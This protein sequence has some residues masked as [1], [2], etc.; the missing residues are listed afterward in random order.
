AGASLCVNAGA[1]L[2]G[3]GGLTLGDH[4]LIGPNAVVLSSQHRWDDPTPPILLQGQSLLPTDG[5]DDVWI[6]AHAGIVAGGRVARGTVVAAGAVVTSDTE[7]YPI[8]GGVPAGRIGVR[9]GTAV[10]RGVAS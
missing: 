10:A 3:R 7:P 2:D 5:G 4:V 9:P 1:F 6:G 8:V